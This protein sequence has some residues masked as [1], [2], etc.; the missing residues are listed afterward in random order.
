MA[1]DFIPIDTRLA[2]ASQAGELLNLKAAMQAAY[3]QGLKVRG[4]M[5]HCHEGTE[6]T[7]LEQLFGVPAGQGQV[8][9][10]LVNGAIGSME[11][12]FMVDDCKELCERI[13]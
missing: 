2:G 11:G 3:S 9:F 7:Y 4:I 12:E 13:G 10:D 5:L 8:V 6:F 1:Q